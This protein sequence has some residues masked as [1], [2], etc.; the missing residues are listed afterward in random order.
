M[1]DI[2]Y[3]V[4]DILNEYSKKPDNKSGDDR[5]DT[6][7]AIDDLEMLFESRPD[8]KKKK[9]FEFDNTLMD[10]DSLIRKELAFDSTQAILN[11]YKAD[12]SAEDSKLRKEMYLDSTQAII[13]SYTDKEEKTAPLPKIP[14]RPIMPVHNEEKAKPLEK[15]TYKEKPHTQA[16][17]NS[18][19]NNQTAS[20]QNADKNVS[21]QQAPKKEDLIK[22][23]GQNNGNSEII[24]SI[25]KLKKERMYNKT[26][27]IV[28]INRKNIG[29]IKLDITSKIIPKTEQIDVGAQKAEFEELNK[30][31][32]LKEKRKAKIRDFVLA[33]DNDEDEPEIND[34]IAEND[35]FNDIED[36]PAVLSEI[37]Q[38][39]G[40]LLTRLCI[41]LIASLVCGYMVLANDF[42]WPV[43]KMMNLAKSPSAFTMINIIIGLLCTLVCGSVIKNGLVNLFKLNADADSL[44]TITMIVSLITSIVFMFDKSLLV[45]GKIH[46]YISAGIVCLLFNT[47]GKLFIVYRTERNFRYVSSDNKKY[48][49]TQIE[50]SE[51]ASRFTRGALSGFPSLS[52]MNE[53][54]F[55][56]DFLKNSFAPDMSDAYCKKAV[57]AVLIASFVIAVLS[58]ILN[59][60]KS[61]NEI[62]FTALTTF[63]GT[64]ALCSPF[65]IMLVV[66][67]PFSRTSKKLLQASSCMVGYD[68]VTKFEDTNSVLID[69][70]Q[71]FPEGSVE[72]INLKQ[73][74]SITLEEGIVYA[75]SLSCHAGSILNSTFYNMLKGKT[76]ILY[77]VESYLYE[78]T[79]GL[80]GWIENK[81]ILLGTREL[82]INHSIEGLPSPTKEAGYA[83]GN[84]VLYLSV[85]GEIATMFIIKAKA[86]IAISKWL[87]EFE[88]NEITV[89]L[90]SV[91]SI[92]S[93][94]Y[95]SEIFHVSPETFK[96]L[97]F[98]QHKSFEATTSYIEKSSTSLIGSGKFKSFAMLILATRRLRRTAVCGTSI[99]LN[100]VILGGIIALI[101]TLLGSFGQ[102]TS[103]IALLYNL[104]WVVITYVFLHFRK[105]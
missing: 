31:K 12:T 15:V 26:S 88:D 45:N 66:N 55:I 92:I 60:D 102:I 27:E 105:A 69:V 61:V 14:P 22:P 16:D 21:A 48:A 50:D 63:S 39:K 35:D 84:L 6:S 64:I 42:G 24:E 82:M 56:D 44:P 37:L 49:L 78:D 72:L 17:I 103:S 101:M 67:I 7:K 25:L 4:D 73:M 90:R 80:S 46:I 86:S 2:K 89:I 75:A 13:D 58:V 30:M 8:K 100:S 36:A 83:N 94:K 71:L 91:D 68:A 70:N 10:D 54:E 57:P 77:P 96:L 28:A 40:T 38:L 9:S 104:A 3:S 34:E 43:L 5:K 99:V 20:E 93:L 59:L 85:S 29:D 32:M 11:E 53:T 81:R 74:S 97:P 23:I 52:T 87:Q 79:L 65:A 51:K 19:Q 18:E 1:S 62:I 47:I 41:L 95:L 98:R 33:G 76:E